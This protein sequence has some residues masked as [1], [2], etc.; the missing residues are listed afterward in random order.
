MYFCLQ[1]LYIS[2]SYLNGSEFMKSKCNNMNRCVWVWEINKDKEFWL[3][4]S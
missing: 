3:T 4:V 1:L 2:N